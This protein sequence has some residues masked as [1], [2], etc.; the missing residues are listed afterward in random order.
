[1]SDETVKVAVTVRPLNQRELSHNASIVVSMKQHDRGSSTYV[2]D[3]TG[4][5]R[6]YNFD[7]SFNLCHEDPENLGVFADQKYVF[8]RVGGPILDAAMEGKNVC[9][10]AYGQTGAGKTWTMLG[11]DDDESKRGI[12]PRTCEAIF[13][14]IADEP[15]DAEYE[16]R[17]AVWIQVVEV[18]CEQV[19]DLLLPRKD[20]PASG[21][22]PE[23]Q[24]DGSYGVRTTRQLCSCMSDIDTAFRRAFFNRTV[25]SHEM[26]QNSSRA[27]T[28]YT[29]TYER[30]RLNRVSGKRFELLTSVLSLI[31]LA[32][33]ER[34][35][36]A[37][38]SGVML[39]EGTMI[40][41]SLST[42]SRCISALAA[43]KP[44]PYRESV[45]TLLLKGSMTNGKVLMIAAVS[46]ASVCTDETISTLAFADNIK[47]V[48]VR[49]RT[50]VSLDPAAEVKKQMAV[51]KAAMQSEIDELRKLLQVAQTNGGG[52]GGAPADD[53]ASE[54]DLVRRLN[55]RVEE[56]RTL[57]QQMK[58]AYERQMAEL[59]MS[60]EERAAAQGRHEREWAGTMA[61]TGLHEGELRP[62]IRNLAEDERL[63]EMMA[64]P[65]EVGENI[66]GRPD[67]ADP[68]TIVLKGVGMMRRHA[69][70]HVEHD[71]DDE[72]AVRDKLTVRR[73]R[74]WIVPG[75]KAARVLVNGA[76][77]RKRTELRHDARVWLA[78]NYIFRF[79]HPGHEDRRDP[80]PDDQPVSWMLANEE[81]EEALDP[82][83]LRRAGGKGSA[84]LPDEL[85]VQL[86][87]ALQNVEQCNG[88]AQDLS[89]D[90]FFRARLSK[91]RLENV[92]SVIVEA[93]LFREA[94]VWGLV[95]FEERRFQM[96]S[97]WQH[98]RDCVDAGEPFE[99]P[100]EANPF[101]DDDY[102][103][104]GEAQL[105]LE[106]LAHMLDVRHAVSIH[107]P[108]NE[109]SGRLLAEMQPL[110][111]N[112]N[113]GPFSDQDLD[114]FVDDPDE[115]LYQT[116]SFQVKVIGV[117]LHVQP[118]AGVPFA[119]VFCRYRIDGR[120]DEEAWNKTPAC[121]GSAI[122]PRY[123]STH[124]HSLHVT[125]D[126]LKHLKDG[127][128]FV[129]IWGQPVGSTATAAG[130]RGS[131]AP[132]DARAMQK[133]L[134]D[135]RME[136][137]DTRRQ[138]AEARRGVADGA[139]PAATANG[140]Q[141]NGTSSGDAVAVHAEVE[142]LQR[143]EAELNE[144]VG[145]LAEQL[146]Q[147]LEEFA[148]LEGEVGAR[149]ADLEALDSAVVRKKKLIDDLDARINEREAILR[150]LDLPD[151][152]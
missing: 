96:V 88:I 46:P 82:A 4:K 129:Q 64:H 108:L 80:T 56:E 21:F 136:L 109:T 62:H 19:N 135:L 26:N 115:L 100:P 119:N 128:A 55:E 149:K 61:T 37:G 120:D 127:A 2:T 86:F 77:V 95:N 8:D 35:S 15:P 25:G 69:T 87:E 28:I 43:G 49:V 99:I 145:V 17:S 11:S 40:N 133:T 139:A 130:R 81:A 67:A 142:R 63:N 103:L 34:T 22:K 138:L 70:V 36:K 66:I 126:V 102:Q 132:M 13:R 74:V 114:P 6:T 141:A 23:M 27:H 101:I 78:G 65:F 110:D 148:R 39:H 20:W 42:L 18:Y 111:R 60:A 89:V 94:R 33:S 83:G 106:T 93:V 137:D 5:R 32:G 147:L 47:K 12:I 146:E 30:Q 131:N 98:W 1:M 73:T 134:A 151:E 90:A 71:G 150:E 58:E 118:G 124:E 41:K 125:P 9:L 59:E 92:T 68:P 31:D 91:S 48:R 72:V 54:A 140:P 45:L 144:K 122:A 143:D 107:S 104:V 84:G 76:A 123:T 3:S 117:D 16:V 44:A 97:L 50:N 10:F 105:P 29:I 24:P 152:G 52:G 38:T 113:P 112:G 57:Q 14:K 116:I 53:E 79:V 51:M 121:P 75:D 85:A 7:H